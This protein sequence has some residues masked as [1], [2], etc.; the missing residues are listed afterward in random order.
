[1]N[2]KQMTLANMQFQA[3]AMQKHIKELKIEN[4]RAIFEFFWVPAVLSVSSS[5]WGVFNLPVMTYGF[6]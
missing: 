2:E 5:V 3:S 4:I 6:R 1:M